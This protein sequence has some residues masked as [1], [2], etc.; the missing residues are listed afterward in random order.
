MISDAFYLT[1]VCTSNRAQICCRLWS[2]AVYRDADSNFRGRSVFRV[3][4]TR[5]LGAT[6]HGRM[7]YIVTAVTTSQLTLQTLLNMGV[8]RKTDLWRYPSLISQSVRKRGH[9]VCT[10]RKDR[11]E[12]SKS[13]SY[14]FRRL[15]SQKTQF[16]FVSLHDNSWSTHALLSGDR[17]RK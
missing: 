12:S 4:S 2:D 15:S 7:F 10:T 14:Y 1:T 17:L 9:S 8:F 6:S 16:S 5:V 11:K 3:S 13:Q